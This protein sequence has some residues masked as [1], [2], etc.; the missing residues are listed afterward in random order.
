M[1]TAKTS[2]HPTRT[3]Y[4]TEK[5]R[6]DYITAAIKRG[7]L[8]EDA[9]RMPD[10]VS[11]DAPTDKRQPIQFWQLY[12]VLGQEPIVQIV[13]AFYERVFTD[14]D[15]FKS[16]F[17]RVGGVDHHVVTQASMWID[18]MGGGPYYH[19]AEFRLN[20]HHYH[21]A[22]ALMNDRG[23]ER[24]T[25][26]MRETLDASM[27]LMAHDDRIRTSINT[28][29]SFFMDKYA[30]DFAF[31]AKEFFGETNPP[32]RQKINFM[33]M[34]EDAIKALSEE[35]IRNALAEMGVDVSRYKDKDA[36]LNKALML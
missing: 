27:P 13:K 7:L 22:M 36:L 25:T 15:W 8:P 5:I 1:G 31:E 26:L 16:V 21:N 11:M 9:H 34:T 12:S 3:G 2:L 18:A 19:G 35:D 17:A 29:L 24:W 20:F 14:E 10:T 33:R 6:R 4:L 30:A 32:Y 28:F 23:A